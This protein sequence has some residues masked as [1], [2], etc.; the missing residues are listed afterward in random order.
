MEVLTIAII[1]GLGIHLGMR[2]IWHGYDLSR[3]FETKFQRNEGNTKT[4]DSEES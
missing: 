2:V 4:K 3:M 1:T